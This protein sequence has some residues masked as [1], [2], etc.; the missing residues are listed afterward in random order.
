MHLWLQSQHWVCVEAAEMQ[1]VLVFMNLKVK[2]QWKDVSDGVNTGGFPEILS[3]REFRPHFESKHRL[4]GLTEARFHLHTV[5]RSTEWPLNL[6][7]WLFSLCQLWLWDISQTVRCHWCNVRLLWGGRVCFTPIWV[8]KN[9]THHLWTR[10]WLA[11][12][13]SLQSFLL[14]ESMCNLN[15]FFKNLFK[16]SIVH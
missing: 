12:L 5:G 15:L 6:Q 1:L 9:T 4:L 3:R 16:N 8:I 14:V 7:R 2:T 11:L 10:L 13:K